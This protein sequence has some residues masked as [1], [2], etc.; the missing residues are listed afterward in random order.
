M[1]NYTDYRDLYFGSCEAYAALTASHAEVCATLEAA[2]ARVA[3]LE[4]QLGA[5]A[6][7]HRGLMLIHG[8][9]IEMLNEANARIAE[10]ETQR[11]AANKSAQF[12]TEEARALANQYRKAINGIDTAAKMLSDLSDRAV[13][14]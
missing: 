9:T 6:A 1:N 3:E 12:W 2:Q 13:L 11:N 7:E 14:P 5:R 8:D 4:G 10:L